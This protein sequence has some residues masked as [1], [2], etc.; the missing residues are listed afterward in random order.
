LRVPD[1]VPDSELLEN[2]T[3]P[4][5]EDGRPIREAIQTLEYGNGNYW[6]GD[7]MVDHTI[8]AA[9]PIFERAFPGCQALFAFDNA[10]NHTS[11]ADDALRV[12]K[13]NLNPG[14]KQS[15]MRDGYIH[16]QQ[17]PQSMIFPDDHPNR[18][19]A[20]QPKGIKQVLVE[21]GLWPQSGQ[22]SDGLAFLLDCSTAD[23][24]P[25]C[26]QDLP[27]GCCARSLLGAQQDFKEQ[28]GR[29]QEEVEA[30][31]HEVIFYPKFHCEL[32]FIERFWCLAKR[33]LRDNCEYSIGG[34]RKNLPKALASVSSV[35]INRFYE[36][37]MR[38][39]SAYSSGAQYGTKEFRERM[40][41]G[42]RQV[43]DK[44]K[45]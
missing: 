41:R 18:K 38:I 31:G 23:G 29:I 11:Y 3:W 39:I 17:R 33:W 28:S 43:V 15:R 42:H 40:Y 30:G 14:G 12:E 13:M 32:N 34:L 2:A 1:N 35:S 36:H 21:R 10:S 26:S 45:W 6:T 8:K 37:C 9:I 27:G 5:Y 20:G 19:F 22:R 4:K 25:G 44:S 24:K 16:N 7:K